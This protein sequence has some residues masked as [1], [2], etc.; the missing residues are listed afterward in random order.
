MKVLKMFLIGILFSTGFSVAE[1]ACTAAEAQQKA[2]TFSTQ[3]QAFAQKNPQKYATVMQE[4][5][6]QLLSIQQNPSDLD[7]VCKFYD[8]ALAKL[9]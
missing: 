3:A 1:A 7:K 6:P 2:V 4:L 5:Q 9:K 8:D